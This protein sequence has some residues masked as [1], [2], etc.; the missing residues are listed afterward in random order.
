MQ[1]RSDRALPALL[2][3]TQLVLS[4]QIAP[5]NAVIAKAERLHRDVNNLSSKALFRIRDAAF[6]SHPEVY[7]GGGGRV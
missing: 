2:D 3:E 1:S 7:G 6:S 5:L 4:E